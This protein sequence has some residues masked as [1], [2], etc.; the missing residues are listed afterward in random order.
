M[1]T[2]EVFRDLLVCPALVGLIERDRRAAVA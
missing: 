1:A 2:I